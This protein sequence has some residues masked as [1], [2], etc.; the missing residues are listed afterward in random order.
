MSEPGNQATDPTKS[1]YL[2][3]GGLAVVEGVMMRSPHH[4]A[5]ACRAPNGKI[6]VKTDP[7][8]QTWVGKQRWL[9]KPFLRGTL[10]LLDTMALGYKAMNWASEVQLDPNLG[11]P[12][13]AKAA[14]PRNKSLENALIVLSVVGGLVLQFFIFRQVPEWVAEAIVRRVSNSPDVNIHLTGT[15]YLAEVIK[16]VLFIGFLALVSRFPSMMEVFRYHGAEHKAINTIEAH[17]S[18]TVDHCMAQTRLHP[19]CGTNFLIIITILAFI[20]VPAIPRD[21]IAPANS[22]AWL[23]AL[24]RLPINLVV[25]PILAGIA[26]EIIRAAGKAK[27][28]RWVK[29]LLAPGLATQLITTAEPAA[30]HIEVAIASLKAVLKAEKEGTLTQSDDWQDVEAVSA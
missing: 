12:T 22:P 24:S 3:F 23:L 21:L 17:E 28:Q 26:Y 4:Y 7:L 18:L 29:F 8:T 16:V 19:R 25:L 1:E 15:N 13:S 30:K 5:V 11:A 14:A 6:V 2:T 10:A 20:I 27:D 9:K